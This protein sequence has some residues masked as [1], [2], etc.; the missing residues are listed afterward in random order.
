MWLLAVSKASRLIPGALFSPF[1]YSHVA[2]AGGRESGS[3][4]GWMDGWVVEL[5]VRTTR[6]PVTSHD[7]NLRHALIR[8]PSAAGD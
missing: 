6:V 5:R 2:A 4:D 1:L 7:P 8:L 3:L